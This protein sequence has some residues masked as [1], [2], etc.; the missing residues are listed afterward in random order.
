MTTKSG[1]EMTTRRVLYAMLG[2]ALSLVGGSASAETTV[3]VDATSA[4]TAG[5]MVEIVVYDGTSLP[6]TTVAGCSEHYCLG[7]TG[8]PTGNV[9]HVKNYVG[10]GTVG[11]ATNGRINL[12]VDGKNVASARSTKLLVWSTTNLT[13][14]SHTLVGQAYDSTG[15]QMWS[16]PLSINV[17]K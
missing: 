12:I 8:I 16:T 11:G 13:A 5:P 2:I 1:N 3:I 15:A 10:W 6:A 7:Y 17:I 4:T 14:G 9:T